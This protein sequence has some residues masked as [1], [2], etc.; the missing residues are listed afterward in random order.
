MAG[1]M[2]ISLNGFKSHYNM[3]GSAYELL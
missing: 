2:H 3:Q 1:R